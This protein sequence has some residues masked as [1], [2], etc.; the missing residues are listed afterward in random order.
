LIVSS[1]GD[2][3]PQLEQTIAILMEKLKKTPAGEPEVPA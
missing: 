3:D 2:R 1:F